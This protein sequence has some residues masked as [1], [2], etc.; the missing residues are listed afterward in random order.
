M[1]VRRINTAQ[2]A[3]NGSARASAFPPISTAR[4]AS[5]RYNL[6]T[7]QALKAFQGA[8]KG[9]TDFKID[10]DED[11]GSIM[12]YQ[13]GKVRPA[14]RAKRSTLTMEIADA[15]HQASVWYHDAGP[16][17]PSGPDF[18]GNWLFAEYS[19]ELEDMDADMGVLT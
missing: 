14:A 16:H 18:Q 13:I 6:F 5:E 15:H 8:V 9:V 19:V 2:T 3:K 12:K 17:R 4:Q 11:Y 1:T 7:V 10:E